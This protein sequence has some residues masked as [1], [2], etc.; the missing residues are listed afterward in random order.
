MLDVEGS[1]ETARQSSEAA[2][3]KDRRINQVVGVLDRYG[4]VVGALQETKWFV[5]EVYKDSC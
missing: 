3:S 2:T 1:V 5:S 4:I